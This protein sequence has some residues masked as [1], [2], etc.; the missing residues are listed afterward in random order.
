MADALFET[1]LCERLGVEPLDV[2]EAG[3]DRQPGRNEHEGDEHEPEVGDAPPGASHVHT[4]PL[5]GLGPVLRPP[6]FGLIDSPPLSPRA[7]SPLGSWLCAQQRLQLRPPVSGLER[8]VENGGRGE[9][10]A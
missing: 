1:A 8:L 10:G 7:R 5:T 6:A 4:A 3:C 2:D 9:H